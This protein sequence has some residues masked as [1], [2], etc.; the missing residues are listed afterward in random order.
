M[1]PEVIFF[2]YVCFAPISISCM[3]F[4]IL[5]VY[6][7]SEV[8]YHSR[9]AK[10]I[11]LIYIFQCRK[12]KKK[13]PIPDHV[14]KVHSLWEADGVKDVCW[15]G[16]VTPMLSWRF[17]SQRV[18]RERQMWRGI[19]P[20]TCICWDQAFQISHTGHT[21]MPCTRTTR[22]RHQLPLTT[23]EIPVSSVQK[24]DRMG[25]SWGWT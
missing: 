7:L 10:L 8:V 17:C 9:C 2:S 15:E 11:M 6:C 23:C 14:R 18:K 24:S 13:T 19:P 5:L 21:H 3:S 22:W 12:I 20:S 1:Y 4:I 16:N 25:C